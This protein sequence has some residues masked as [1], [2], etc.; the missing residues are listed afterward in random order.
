MRGGLPT[1]AVGRF[2]PPTSYDDEPRLAPILQWIDDRES[3]VLVPQLYR[4]T[5]FWS[6][7]EFKGV[8]IYSNGL[9]EAVLRYPEASE[10]MIEWL[11]RA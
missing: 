9:R 5:A 4:L 1:L 6:S 7:S 8:L 2:H 11:G 10:L 3:S